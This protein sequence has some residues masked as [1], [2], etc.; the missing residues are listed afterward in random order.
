MSEIYSRYDRVLAWL[1]PVDNNGETQVYQ[2]AEWLKN[3]V[4]LSEQE[5][6]EDNRITTFM[7]LGKSDDKARAQ[8]EICWSPTMVR[9]IL[10]LQEAVLTQTQ[11]IL[12]CGPYELGYDIFLKVLILMPDQS[13]DKQLLYA[14]MVVNPVRF[15]V[16]EVAYKDILQNRNVSGQEGKED[17][18]GH[19]A[20]VVCAQYSLRDIPSSLSREHKNLSLPVWV[21]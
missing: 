17:I 13:E 11:P 2:L 18:H 15:K 12:L 7:E 20:K 10:I 8:V 19:C 4:L 1:G 5:C 9:R 6:I 21:D 14:F 16:T 3:F